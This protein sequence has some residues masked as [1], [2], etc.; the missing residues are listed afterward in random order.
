MIK[1]TESNRIRRQNYMSN[2]TE[3]NA[4][5][6]NESRIESNRIGIFQ[7]R[8]ESSR[9]KRVELESNRFESIFLD[10]FRALLCN[11]VCTQRTTNSISTTKKD[12]IFMEKMFVSVPQSRRTAKMHLFIYSSDDHIFMVLF[13]EATS[14]KM[15]NATEILSCT[16]QIDS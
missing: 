5:F 6:E 4:N 15:T 8:I 16:I 10:S 14:Y 1:I 2:R 12:E 3:P 11:V 13:G 9:K 7:K